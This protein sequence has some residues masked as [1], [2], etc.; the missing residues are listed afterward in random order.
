MVIFSEHFLPTRG[1]SINW[2]VNSYGRYQRDGVLFVVGGENSREG[3][4]EEVPFPIYRIDM[5]MSD[6]DPCIPS[7]LFRYIRIILRLRKI[8]R[9]HD[10]QQIHCAKVLP[11]GLVAWFIKQIASIPYILYAHGEE[12]TVGLTARKFQWLLPRIYNG[13]GAIIA[14]SFNTRALL[15]DIGVEADKI[16]VIHPGVDAES[17]DLRASEV[18]A[19]QQKHLLGNCPVILTVGRMQRRKGQDMVI[20]ALPRLKKKFSDIK[21]L[22]VGTGE[23]SQYLRQLAHNCGVS[24]AVIFAGLVPDKDL[25]AYYSVCDVFIM[26]NREID[27]DIEGFGMVFLE[28]NAA[29][30]PVIGG[31]SG[32]TGDA[33]VHGVTGLRVDGTD[34][35]AISDSVIYLLKDREKARNMGKAGRRRVEEEFTWESV[36]DRTMLISDSVSIS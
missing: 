36:A 6:W 23:E 7:S 10:I 9:K 5:T 17:Y 30:K 3:G 21:Y 15:G 22:I 4:N 34:V 2:L 16:H 1:G 24:D 28:A 18:E 35:K 11:E 25:P 12:I 33:I 31:M 29:R 8:C 20:K 13:A 19:I 26:P 14:N 27:G 32:G